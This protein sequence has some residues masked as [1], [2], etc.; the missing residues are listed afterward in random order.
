M[1]KGFYN[2]EMIYKNGFICHDTGFNSYSLTQNN[3]T[4]LFLQFIYPLYH[5]ISLKY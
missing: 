1:L 2:K 5:I 4:L 3:K